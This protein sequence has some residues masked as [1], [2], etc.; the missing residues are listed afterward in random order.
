MS[1]VALIIGSLRR[2]GNGIGI[3]NWLTPVLRKGLSASEGSSTTADLIFV[4]STKPPLPLGPIIDASHVPADIRD[5]SQH[6]NPRV[7]EFAHLVTSCDGFVFL[8]PE[9]NSS[10]PGE[11]KN[12]IDHLYWEWLNKPAIV[13]TYGSAGGTRCAALLRSLLSKS[14]K[15]KLA[16][17]DRDIRRPRPTY[18]PH[19][20][21]ACAVVMV[22]GPRW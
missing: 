21:I 14:F 18:T 4:D 3:A 7:R 9:Y 17:R 10:Y 22:C 2:P 5:P 15:M 8:S 13:I 16:E 12:T 6:P 20:W 11:L 1:K 19:A